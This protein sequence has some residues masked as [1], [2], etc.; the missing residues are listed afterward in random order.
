MGLW[1][2]YADGVIQSLNA[3]SATIEHAQDNPNKSFE[4]KNI[5]SGRT[6]RRP[7]K[8]V[9]NTIGYS[10]SK[11]RSRMTTPGYK[12]N[13]RRRIR[14]GNVGYTRVAGYYG[15]YNR[16]STLSVGEKKFFDNIFTDTN[17][18]PNTGQILIDS[19]NE[20]PQDVTES[21][22]VGRVA[23]IKSMHCRGRLT[24]ASVPSASTVTGDLI[25]LIFFLDKQANGAAASTA[26]IL[27]DTDILSF[28][29]LENSNRFQI[30]REIQCDMNH[31]SAG[32]D[33]GG[34]DTNWGVGNKLFKFNI[35]FPGKGLKIDFNGATG[36][37][38]EIR[39]N[40][41]GVLGISV[42]GVTTITTELCTRLRYTD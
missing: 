28:L 24:I 13:V 11:R 30:L 35:K 16:P 32:G 8:M 6:K 17:G 37:I 26:L 2:D 40:N 4:K 14:A 9:W 36:A 27:Q 10:R 39:S 25:R 42:N 5:F 33:V 18:I 22:R 41:I 12:R 7:N 1:L 20:I 29:N 23:Y 19:I 34:T 15:R 3:V 31:E 21:G 38:T